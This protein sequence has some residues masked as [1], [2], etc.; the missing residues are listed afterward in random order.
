MTTLAINY[1]KPLDDDGEGNSVIMR[2]W[3][4]IFKDFDYA[5]FKPA[6]DKIIKTSAFF[7]KVSE[8]IAAYEQVK[9]EAREKQREIDRAR[10]KALVDGQSHCY[11]CENTGWC[12][13][14]NN[15]AR[16]GRYKITYRCVCAHGKDPN[17]QFTRAMCEKEYIPDPRPG[18][19]I[20]QN[21]A[22]EDGKNPFYRRT[23]KEALGADSF[24][25]YDALK[26][27]EWLE[28]KGIIDA[29]GG[30]APGAMAVEIMKKLSELF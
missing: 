25:V 26:K 6:C 12:E 13:Y 28:S 27:A 23:I 5:Y 24:V 1:E 29:M 19:T 11:L 22:I 17:K 15:V 16:L 9:R 14:W 18:H 8:V 4:D 20:E 7:P 3:C 21:A 30:A 10:H 2:L